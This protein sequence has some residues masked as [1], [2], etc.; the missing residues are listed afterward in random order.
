MI[1]SPSVKFQILGGK[2]YLRCKGKTL[3]G[4]V[5]NLLKTKSL[6]TSPSNVLP[7]Y[8]KYFPLQF[9]FSLKVIAIGWKHSYL[10]KNFLLYSVCFYFIENEQWMD[11]FWQNH[12]KIEWFGWPLKSFLKREPSNICL[13][14]V[15][16]LILTI[17]LDVFSPCLAHNWPIFATSENNNKDKKFNTYALWSR[18][19]YV[20]RLI[21]VWT[22]VCFF[23]RIFTQRYV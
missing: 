1:P 2:V 3:L 14:K 12:I 21:I 7:H 18:S 5:N 16:I 13:K 15:K 11:F 23:L 20:F 19:S 22:R 9:E 10:L 6:L 17:A 8:L 4:V